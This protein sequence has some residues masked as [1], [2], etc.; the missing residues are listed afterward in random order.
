MTLAFLGFSWLFARRAGASTLA[1]LGF[2]ERQP[3]LFLAFRRSKAG[4]RRG[5]FPDLRR[6]RDA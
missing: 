2:F 3:W 6:A 1:F 4:R 5:H